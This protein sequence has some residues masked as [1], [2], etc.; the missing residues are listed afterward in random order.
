MPIWDIIIYL[1]LGAIVWFIWGFIK[2]TK[3]QNPLLADPK[4]FKAVQKSDKG[5]REVFGAITNGGLDDVDLSSKRA[6]RSLAL[7]LVGVCDYFSQAFELN[8]AQFGAFYKT[9]AINF[10]H[11]FDEAVANEAIL[12][13][14]SPDD[15]NDPSLEF[16]K[17]GGTT[18]QRVFGEKNPMALLAVSNLFNQLLETKVKLSDLLET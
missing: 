16:V 1:V 17:L 13:F 5:V 3:K 11:Y 12:F 18:C 9:F 7:Y 6:K 8:D 10:E 14:A 2:H 15:P 4:V